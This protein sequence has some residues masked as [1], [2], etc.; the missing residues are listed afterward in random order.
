MQQKTAKEMQANWARLTEL[1]MV[2][3]PPSMQLDPNLMAEVVDSA[4]HGRV[5]GLLRDPESNKR[6]VPRGGKGPNAKKP[7]FAPDPALPGRDGPE[8]KTEAGLLEAI[9]DTMDFMTAILC[10]H[11]EPDRTAPHA[12]TITDHSAVR[13][14]NGV[15]EYWVLQPAMSKRVVRWF[16]GAVSSGLTHDEVLVVLEYFVVRVDEHLGDGR[17]YNAAFHSVLGLLSPAAIVA[18]SGY[19]R[20]PAAP[21]PPPKGGARPARAAR[22]GSRWTPPQ[23]RDRRRLARGRHLHVLPVEPLQL[24]RLQV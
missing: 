18:T 21:T 15:V 13:N 5:T 22:Q 4:K 6:L 7:A 16:Q 11:M 24:H 19:R 9:S 23:G 8:T 2:D 1:T 10:C 20:L 17:T 12:L 14:K 3:Y